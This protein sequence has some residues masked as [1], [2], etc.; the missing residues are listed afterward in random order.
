MWRRTC[1]DFRNGTHETRGIV[2]LPNYA[3]VAMPNHLHFVVRPETSD[4]VSEFFCRRTVMHAMRWHAY[5][6]TGARDI[7]IRD[8]SNCFRFIRTSTCC[9]WS[10]IRFVQVWL[11]SRKT[12]NGVPRMPTSNVLTPARW[13]RLRLLTDDWAHVGSPRLPFR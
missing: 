1:S 7:W 10:E 12:G 2:P 11:T 4:Q 3:M 13:R 8:A 9:R 5:N 6:K